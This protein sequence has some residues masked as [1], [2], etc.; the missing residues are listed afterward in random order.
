MDQYLKM[1]QLVQSKQGRDID[2]YF[3]VVSWDDQYVYVANGENRRVQEPKKKNLK[4]LRFFPYL[5]TLIN[6]KLEN[7]VSLTNQEMKRELAE[8]LAV[9]DTEVR[10]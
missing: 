10:E 1:G 5:S 9:Q 4:H 6:E 7:G 2:S 8:L 3:L